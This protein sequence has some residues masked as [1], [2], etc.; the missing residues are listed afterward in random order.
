MGRSI[1]TVRKPRPV[2]RVEIEN[3]NVA[4][5]GIFPVF[6]R[7]APRDVNENPPSLAV[8]LGIV[9]TMLGSKADVL[10]RIKQTTPLDGFQHPH[11]LENPDFKE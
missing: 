9:G 5:R 1:W 8:L 2:C 7:E 4:I 6:H 10:Q 3:L 11:L